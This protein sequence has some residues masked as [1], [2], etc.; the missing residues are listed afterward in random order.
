MSGQGPE[1][2]EGQKSSGTIFLFLLIIVL[3]LGFV[4]FTWLRPVGAVVQQIVIVPRN[5]EMIELSPAGYGV[6]ETEEG[7]RYLLVFIIP[8]DE[9]RRVQHNPQFETDTF[10]DLFVMQSED[11]VDHLHSETGWSVSVE[12][13]GNVVFIRERE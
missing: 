1:R 9:P 3:A 5:G 2:P 6:L 13:G 10:H 8:E 7:G 11:D 12:N 4:L